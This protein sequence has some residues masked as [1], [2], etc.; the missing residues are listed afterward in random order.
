LASYLIIFHEI[1]HVVLGHCDFVQDRMGFASL[2][3]FQ[4]E[5]KLLTSA[6]IRIRKA[7]EAEADRQA[8]EFLITCFESSLGKKGLG[9]YIKFPSRIHV[10]EFYSYAVT[11][12][13]VLL[14]Q[15]SQRKGVVHPKPNE[16]QFIIIS[17][18]SKYF[19]RYKESEHDRILRHTNTMMI[20]AAKKTGLIDGNDPVKVMKNA[21]SLAF[22]D[23]VVNE[24]RIR[25]FQLI[26]G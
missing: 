17:S 14:Q 4:D 13:C 9:Q 10:Y 15:L 19:L 21:I 6:E 3:E 11:L 2:D 26:M 23:D 12:V 1:S 16:R 24:T 5:K 7:F 8:G 18:I 25:D 22:V 20:K